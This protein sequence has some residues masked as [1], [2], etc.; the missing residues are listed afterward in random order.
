LSFVF[1]FFAPLPFR[2][3]FSSRHLLPVC[4]FLLEKLKLHCSSRATTRWPLFL[5]FS[6]KKFCELFPLVFYFF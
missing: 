3:A 6:L 5:L 2:T 4:F 1:F